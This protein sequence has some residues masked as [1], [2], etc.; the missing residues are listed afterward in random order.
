VAKNLL[1]NGF[2]VEQTAK[3]AQLDIEQ[4]KALRR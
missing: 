2:S 4:I 3:Y 1:D